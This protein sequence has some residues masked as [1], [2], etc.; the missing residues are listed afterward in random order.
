MTAHIAAAKAV[1]PRTDLDTRWS[2]AAL[3][4]P[5]EGIDGDAEH[6]GRLGRAQ[7]GIV[8]EIET[9]YAH[10]LPCNAWQDGGSRLCRHME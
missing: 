8:G 9:H 10:S 4:M 5:L 6:R 7:Y 3:G 1:P 2:I